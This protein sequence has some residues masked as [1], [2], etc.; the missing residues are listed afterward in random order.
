MYGTFILWNCSF[1]IVNWGKGERK[2]KS[3][4]KSARNYIELKRAAIFEKKSESTIVKGAVALELQN[5][6]TLYGSHVL[7]NG[8]IC[9]SYYGDIPPCVINQRL[10]FL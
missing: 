4:R 9:I 5:L 6:T 8:P 2:S 10:P 1:R 3:R 7:Y